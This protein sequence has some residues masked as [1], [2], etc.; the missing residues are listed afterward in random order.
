MVGTFFNGGVRAFDVSNQYQ[1][2]EV[3]YFV[4]GAPKLSP[5]GAIQINDVWVDERGLVY[6]VD[7]FGGG[8]YILEMTI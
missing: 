6:A 7:R 2:K 5:K 3:A 8:L 4:P 1:P